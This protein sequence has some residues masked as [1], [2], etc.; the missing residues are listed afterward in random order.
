MKF[1]CLIWG[2]FLILNSHLLH[3][4]TTVTGRV[5]DN[6]GFSIAYVNIRA[7][8]LPDSSFLQGTTTNESGHFTLSL[9]TAGSFLLRASFIGYSDI[10]T[11]VGYGQ[12]EV[13]IGVL[14][15]F[16]AEQNLNEVL[17]T[18]RKPLYEQKIDR[19]IVNVQGSLLSSGNSVLSV[20]NK[21]PA[22][23]VNPSSGEVSMLGKQG[24]LIM[25]NDKPL[26]LER[27]DLISYLSSLSSDNI[28]TIELITSPPA[29]YDAQGA[30]GIINITLIRNE[31][32]IKGELVPSVGFGKRP[33]YSNGFNI[34]FQKDRFYF[35][36]LLNTSLNFDLEQVDIRTASEI[37][38]SNSRLQIERKPQTGLYTGDFGIDYKIGSK[39]TLSALIS[40]LK[41]DWRMN[42]ITK[43][44]VGQENFYSSFFTKSYEEN[45]LF[46]TLYNLNFKHQVNSKINLTLEASRID[47]KRENPTT[48]TVE[49]ENF[50]NKEQFLSSATT[51]VNVTVLKGDLDIKMVENASLQFGYK[52]SLSA[53]TNDVNVAN[54]KDGKWIDNDSFKNKF[55]LTEDIHAAYLNLNWKPF[56]KL[57]SKAG[58]R[59]EHYNLDLTSLKEGSIVSRRIGNF[60]PSVFLSYDISSE[61][62]L[63]T[64][65]VSRIQRPGFLILA[66]YF[67]FFDQNTLTT[68]NPMILP[69]RINQA[70]ISYSQPSFNLSFQHSREESPILDFQPT[71]NNEIDIVE[72]KPIQ[73]MRNRSSSI[74][75]NIPLEVTRWWNVGLN[76]IGYHNQQKFMVNNQIYERSILSYEARLNQIFSITKQLDMELTAAY[77]SRNIYGTLDVLSRSQIDLGI[78]KKFKSNIT[79]SLA[80]ND[81]LNTGTQWPNESKI[82][83]DYLNY[84]FNFDAEGPVYRLSL[85]LPFGKSMTK[86]QSRTASQIEEIKRVN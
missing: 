72:I 71:I 17:V 3:G 53:F 70:Q 84:Y 4:Q 56:L 23:Q 42:S 59:F 55:E 29:N 58:L 73:G 35:Y 12:T 1:S 26:R 40:I 63:S 68:G 82:F 37:L 21:A 15:L 8:A 57:T 75:L 54:F 13:N 79:L 24:V 25:V 80:V 20:L 19:T 11:E 47:F 44:Q 16:P 22:V 43:S 85:S 34:S 27:Q 74:N 14:S 64:S 49:D 83:G 9:E 39:S 61:K 41:S 69:S 45:L 5:V 18:G 7:L 66:P 65:F 81:L 62:T 52:T 32:G 30:A 38:G 78:R 67:Y 33:K 50:L 28:A 86:S 6:L 46:R 2:L 77:Y 51:P 36:S 48:Y 31:N 60:F 10:T 76:A